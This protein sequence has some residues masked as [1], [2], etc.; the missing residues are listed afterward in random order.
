MQRHS[1]LYSSET[2]SLLSFPDSKKLQN[3]FV[4]SE[5]ERG[6]SRIRA[7]RQL[8]FV[9][10]AMRLICDEFAGAS[11]IPQSPESRCKYAGISGRPETRKKR[12]QKTREKTKKDGP[13]DGGQDK[14]GGV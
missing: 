6:E 9:S 11:Y 12:R 1:K 10:R 13:R 5:L 3:S 2:R 4:R 8:S 7:A 14:G